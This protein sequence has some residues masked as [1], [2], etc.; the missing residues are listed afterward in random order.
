M[1][2]VEYVTN[3]FACFYPHQLGMDNFFQSILANILMDVNFVCDVLI[4]CVNNNYDVLIDQLILWYIVIH[5]HISLGTS[6]PR[7]SQIMAT[8]H[9]QSIR[10]KMG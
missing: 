4:H 6:L 2:L 10:T 1:G 7:R 5:K 9:V 3:F 8:N